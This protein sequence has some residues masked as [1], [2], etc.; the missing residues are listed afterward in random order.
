MLC[1]VERIS[2]TDA[3][4]ETALVNGETSGSCG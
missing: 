4:V 3:A 2:G 1:V